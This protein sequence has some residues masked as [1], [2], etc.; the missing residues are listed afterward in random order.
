MPEIVTLLESETSGPWDSEEPGTGTIDTFPPRSLLLIRQTSRVQREILELLATGLRTQE[1]AQ[2]LHLS[3][4]T[5]SNQLT[6][7]FNKLGVADRT[8][9]VIAAREYGLGTQR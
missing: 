1:I 9:A 4:K 3:S 8:A 5:V 7:I 6:A 2:T